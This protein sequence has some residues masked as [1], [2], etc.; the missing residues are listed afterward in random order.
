MPGLED[1]VPTRA[2]IEEEL[3]KASQKTNK[4]DKHSRNQDRQTAMEAKYK[5]LPGNSLEKIL[6]DIPS[7]K[8]WESEI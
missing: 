5:H 3:R 7:Y 8:H 6:N 1:I 2:E 4:A